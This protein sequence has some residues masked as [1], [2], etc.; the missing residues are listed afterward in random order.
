MSRRFTGEFPYA[1]NSVM[2]YGE[3]LS[4]PGFRLVS[5]AARRVSGHGW[6][7]SHSLLPPLDTYPP[8]SGFQTVDQS[9]IHGAGHTWS[10]WRPGGSYTG[11][12]RSNTPKEIL[13]IFLLHPSSKENRLASEVSGADTR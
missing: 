8:P 1:R 13:R 7:D 12:Q 2:V 4:L 3:H 10:G 6:L 11:P 5:V 9:T